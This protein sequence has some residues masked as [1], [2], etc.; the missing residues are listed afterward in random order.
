MD[1]T[2]KPQP[3]SLPDVI[4]A[5]KTLVPKEFG[6]K[7]GLFKSLDDVKENSALAASDAMHVHWNT[8]IRSVEE[9]VGQPK[10]CPWF[11]KIVGV[12][13]GTIDHKELL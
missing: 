11:E 2:E 13:N 9:H 4:E 3:R 10:D 6:G 8:L 7:E 1:E 12:I 5:I